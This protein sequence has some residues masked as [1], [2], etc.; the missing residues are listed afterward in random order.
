MARGRV[1]HGSGIADAIL[2]EI[3]LLRP[4]RGR[5]NSGQPASAFRF[6]PRASQLWR[7]ALGSNAAV[8]KKIGRGGTRSATELRAQ[9]DYLFSKSAAIFGNA[10][11]HDPNARDLAA[12]ERREIAATWSDG[13]TGAPKNGQTSHLLL[14][15]PSH[16]RPG[17]AKL[18]AEAW[19]FEMFQSGAHR[20][21]EWAYVAALHTDRAHPHVHIVLNNRGLVHG[22][23]FFMARDH[24]FNLAM[25]KERMVEIAAEEGVFLDATSRLERGILTYGPSRAEIERAKREG[26]APQERSREGKALEDALACVSR[27]AEIMRGLAHV[28]ALTGLRDIADRIGAA[29][30]T[31]RRGGML[32]PFPTEAGQADRVDLERHF[33]D[34]MAAASRKIAR[35]PVA[36]Q[37]GLRQEIYGYAAG[38]ARDLGD[39]RGAELMSM[40]P[41]TALYGTAWASP[42]R[43]GLIP[44]VV[45]AGAQIG[46]D[47]QRLAARLAS[48][49]ASAFEE[50]DWLR[51]DLLCVAEQ[52]RLDPRRA[53][54]GRQALAVLEAFHARVAEAVD[55]SHA[56][57]PLE[58][59][60]PLLRTLR[61]MAR[62]FPV[63]GQVSFDTDDQAARFAADLRQRYG[64]GIARDLAVGQTTALAR[65]F[66]G[67]DDRRAIA[68][69]VVSAAKAHAGIGL[70]LRQAERAEREMPDVTRR[71]DRE[72]E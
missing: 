19:A 7:F 12:A 18:I 28:A 64:D 26:R 51:R 67:D 63:A 46:L 49:A 48:G 60:D 23:W 56:R 16:V 4:Q 66:P 2:G 5:G 1:R 17:T 68:A 61:T 70:T 44:S 33:G 30:T 69:A 58:R 43:E 54:D 38:I 37:A 11:A 10:V 55:G 39:R 20:G 21:E 47:P 72:L 27:S 57:D 65:D 32:H 40:P 3:D 45:R 62:V 8:L 13:W 53:S 14:S 42:D 35:Q 15:F 59:R 71:R 50:R 31:L 52:T 24:A 29:E 36:V 6:S 9:L 34:W 22:E 25:M 41:G